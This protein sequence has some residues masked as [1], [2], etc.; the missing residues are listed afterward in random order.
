MGCLRLPY[1]SVSACACL[2]WST[3]L[4]CLPQK[5]GTFHIFKYSTT[6]WYFYHKSVVLKWGTKTNEYLEIRCNKIFIYRF[7]TISTQVKNVH[8]V[9]HIT[10]KHIHTHTVIRD[11]PVD[12]KKQLSHNKQ[13]NTPIIIKSKETYILLTNYIYIKGK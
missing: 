5:C 6:V 4:T 11:I 1:L 7:P 8:Q 10:N 2:T 3:C 13:I 9:L 12:H